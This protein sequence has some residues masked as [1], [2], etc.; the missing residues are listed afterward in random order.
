MKIGI[1]GS[2]HIGSIVGRL[3]AQAG[4]SILF[5]SRHP[6]QL[7]GV[8]ATITGDV[9]VG[10][11]GEAAQFGNVLLLSVPWVGVEEALAAAGSLSGKIVIDTTNQFT[12]TGLQLLPNGRSA[13]EFNARRAQGA[14]WIKAYNTLTAGFQAESAGRTGSE[15][16][17]MPYAGE[18]SDAKRI[19]ATLIRDSG[20]EPFDVGN[21]AEVHWIEPPRRPGAFYGEEWHLDTARTLLAQLTAHEKAGE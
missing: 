11:I 8:V 7:T 17:V 9:R 5:S 16:V 1:I 15:R 4:H 3:W 13:A 20:F 14:R 12:A 19:V 10:T 6:E 18:D 21:W 2:G